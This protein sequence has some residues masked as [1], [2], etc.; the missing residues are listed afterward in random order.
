I[1]EWLPDESSDSLDA[2]ALLT[3]SLPEPE[4]VS[5]GLVDETGR[6]GDGTR[7][8]TRAADTSPDEGPASTDRLFH[9]HLVDEVIQA[10]ESAHPLTVLV[11]GVDDFQSVAERL[12]GVIGNRVLAE[13]DDRVADHV[14]GRGSSSRGGADQFAAVLRDASVSDAETLVSRLCTSLET[15]T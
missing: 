13:L 10:H 5:L 7:L 6:R 9:G 14:E 3:T 8:R 1:V 15:W 4:G 12:G 11:I 2:R